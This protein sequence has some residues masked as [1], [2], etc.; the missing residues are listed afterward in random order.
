VPAGSVRQYAAP[1]Q[2]SDSHRIAD[3]FIGR[4]TWGEYLIHAPQARHFDSSS[5]LGE[6]LS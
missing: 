6:H 2:A 5:Q 1:G 3:T 4:Q